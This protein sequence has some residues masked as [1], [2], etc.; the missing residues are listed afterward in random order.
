LTDF[1]KIKKNRN[2]QYLIKYKEL[3]KSPKFINDLS[4]AWPFYQT[5]IISFCSSQ[6]C[7]GK[8]FCS[9]RVDRRTGKRQTNTMPSS[10]RNPM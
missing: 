10:P 4:L 9:L 2:V 5:G 1:E 3:T 8:S 6:T 7:Q